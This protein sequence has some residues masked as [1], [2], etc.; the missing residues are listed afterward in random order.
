MRRIVVGADLCKG[1]WACIRLVDGRF[2]EAGIFPTLQEA[3]RTFGAQASVIA[4]DIPLSYPAEGEKGRLCETLGRRILGPRS[5]SLFDTYPRAVLEAEPFEVANELARQ[6]TRHGLT[7]QSYALRK[8]IR[9]GVALAAL[10]PR[11]H[12]THPELVFRRLGGVMASKVTWT[13]MRQRLQALEGV[14]IAFPMELP[15]MDAAAVDDVLDAAAAAHAADS[16]A[17]GVGNRV[18]LEGNGGIIWY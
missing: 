4:V 9:E 18:P 17:R 13:G 11:I 1:S 2:E 16:I 8:A 7:K 14:G 15:G 12:E 3:A 5:S 6:T 10:D